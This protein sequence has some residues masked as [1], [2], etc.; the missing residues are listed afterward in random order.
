VF[1]PSRHGGHPAL[2]RQVDHLVWNRAVGEAP[3]MRRN[4]S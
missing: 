4:C 2:K 1:A 3:F